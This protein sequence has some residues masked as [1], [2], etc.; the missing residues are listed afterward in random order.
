[1]SWL[2]KF[3]H[4]EKGYDKAQEQLDKYFG[5]AQGALQPYNQY[6]QSAYGDINAAMKALL[7]PEELQNKWIQGYA[8]SPAAKQAEAL[9][10]EHGLNAASGLGLM[11]SNTALDAIQTGTTQIGLNDRQNYLDNLMQKYLAGVGVGQDIFGKGANAAN[12]MSGNAMNMGQNSAQMAFGKENAQGD[13]FSKLLGGG[14]G[15]VGSAL[16]GPI[17]GALGAGL[18]QKMGWS[19]TGSYNPTGRT[20][21]TGGA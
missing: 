4:P 12:A 18:S 15:L 1:M 3:L 6:G 14:L 7:N 10:Q 9:A 20:F 13:L 11:G 8:E 16:G 21:A 17:G 2:S 19:P 5:Q